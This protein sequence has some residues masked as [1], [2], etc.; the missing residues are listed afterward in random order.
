MVQ[1]DGIKWQVYVKLT[2][3]DYMLAIINETKGRAEYKH[4]TGE[5]SIVE[6]AVAGMGHKKI[7]VANLPPEVPDDTLRTHLAPF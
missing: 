6:I 2:D 3:R 4:T 1:I 7:R 5:I